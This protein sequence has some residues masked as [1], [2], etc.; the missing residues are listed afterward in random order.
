MSVSLAAVMVWP[1]ADWVLP[2]SLAP[3]ADEGIGESTED[4]EEAAAGDGA[5]QP[6]EKPARLLVS[7]TPLETGHSQRQPAGEVPPLAAFTNSPDM[8]D[9]RRFDD[10]GDMP[11]CFM[12]VDGSVWGNLLSQCQT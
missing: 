3:P 9:S 5:A 6:P 7:H 10:S 11:S 4:D 12:A 2:T 8:Q 1:K